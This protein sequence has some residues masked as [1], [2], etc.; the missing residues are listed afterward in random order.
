[1]NTFF[2]DLN[3]KLFLNKDKIEGIDKIKNTYAPFTDTKNNAEED[4]DK[5]N[6]IYATFMATRHHVKEYKKN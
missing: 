4:L 1:M 2:T 6:D 3:S 5:N